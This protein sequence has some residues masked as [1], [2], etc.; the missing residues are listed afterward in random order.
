MVL[1]DHRTAR[2]LLAGATLG[3]LC[4][5][6]AACGESTSLSVTPPAESSSSSASASSG[7]S[8]TDADAPSSSSDSATTDFK[9]GQCLIDTVDWEAAP[10]DQQHKMEVTSVV[11]S[12][13]DA[14]DIVER[15]KLRTWTCNNEL[16]KYLGSPSSAFGRMLAQPVPAAVDPE[17]AHR[18][19][20][21]TALSK[22]DD[23]GY[24]QIDYRLKN[25]IKDKGY[26]PYRICTSNRPSKTG[27]PH[28][29]PCTRAHKAETVGGYVIGKADGKYPG[30]KVV[31]KRALAKCVPL[32][33]KY[34]GATRQDVIATVNSTSKTGW[35]RGITLTA[36]F[37]EATDG[38]FLKPLQGIKNKPLSAYK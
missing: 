28:I 3:I 15:D 18:I 17:A 9:V 2:P 13:K 14:D 32:T 20:C 21:V 19:V 1:T 4:L 38:T 27:V 11:K 30:G 35:Q 22:P 10:C 31:D 26:T 36:C 8:D 37:A 24:E 5:G 33:K 16:A 12:S 23:S 25:R 29:V 6:L 34:L 7:G